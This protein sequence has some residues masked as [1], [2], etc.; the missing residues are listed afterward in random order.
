MSKYTLSAFQVLTAFLLGVFGNKISEI[1]SVPPSV[2]I[3]LTCVLIGISVFAEA[4][5]YRK[6]ESKKQ[7]ENLG[8]NKLT[9][10]LRL[11]RIVTIVPFGIILG[12]V[13]TMIAYYLFPYPSFP[14]LSVRFFY[15]YEIPGYGPYFYE[16]VTYIV[17]CIL[18]FMFSTK[19][20]KEVTVYTLCFGMTIGV[21]VSMSALDPYQPF[22]SLYAWL[23][24]F[25]WLVMLTIASTVILKAKNTIEAMIDFFTKEQT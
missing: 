18:L 13:I 21:V 11:N 17:L 3:L 25:L 8:R 19:Q 6:T 4:S 15:G 5:V 1:V 7:T 2:I 10:P 23:S 20:Q 16:I 22:S 14:K 12:A 24:L 9:L